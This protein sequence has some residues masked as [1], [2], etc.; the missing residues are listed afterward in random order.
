MGIYYALN[1]TETWNL[2]SG[3]EGAK[4]VRSPSRDRGRSKLEGDAR[5]GPSLSRLGCALA[6]FLAASR[7]APA[8]PNF[9]DQNLDLAQVKSGQS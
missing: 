1:L 8:L 3:L 6:F 4:A 9:G 7:P 5:D 2:S